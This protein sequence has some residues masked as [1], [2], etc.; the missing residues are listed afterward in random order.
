MRTV[1]AITV[2]KDSQFKRRH[3][4][5]QSKQG[6]RNLL[7]TRMYYQDMNQKGV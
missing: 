6:E 7:I 3:T 5:L 1:L 2:T 4:E